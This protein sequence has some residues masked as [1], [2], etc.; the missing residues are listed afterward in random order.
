[1]AD[2]AIIIPAY[3]IDYFEYTLES[4][5][6][7]TC[8]N[9]TV[10]IGDDCSSD[11][12]KS[13]IENYKDRISIVYHKFP[14]NKGGVN[15]VSQWKRCVELSHDEQWIWLFSD[16]DVIGE[17]CVELFFHEI[18]SSQS[19]YD[20]YHFD[21]KIV[22]SENNLIRVPRNYPLILS[23][24]QF[25]RKKAS[26]VLD[27]FVVE[28]IFSRRIYTDIDGF[29]DFD[30][31][32]G[33]DIATW[34]K[35]GHNNGIKTIR[36]DYVY[37][38]QSVK[39]ITPNHNN[40]IVFRKFNIDID[41]LSWVNCF[42]GSTKIV[43]FNRYIFFRLLFYY[44]LILTSRQADVV[45]IKAM[46]KN[47]ITHQLYYCLIHTYYLLPFL[48]LVKVKMCGLMRQILSFVRPKR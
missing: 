21:V 22:D 15:L 28:Y 16:D 35:M 23:N 30:L 9:F 7:Q 34:I 36:G 41:F 45:M 25:Y 26:A 14:D 18:G 8:K 42:F 31:A 32:W 37:W 12:F 11:D 47:V 4:L 1:M 39:N 6:M 2:L 13:L 44:S 3:K 24:E 17:R 38:R 29:E 33:S 27:S 20:I 40:D 43:R 48:K 10:Y 5:S 19:H 46:Q